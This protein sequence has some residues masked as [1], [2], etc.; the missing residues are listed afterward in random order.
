MCIACVPGAKRGQVEAS[1]CLELES[2]MV[3]SNYVGVGN[4][5][6]VLCKN[7]KC[8]KLLSHLSSLSIIY[9]CVVFARV[10]TPRKARSRH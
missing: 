1:D 9:L 5:F 6:W 8:S 10:Y 3:V 2:L 4:C 7:N